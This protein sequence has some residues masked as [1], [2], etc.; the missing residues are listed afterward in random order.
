[1]SPASPTQFSMAAALSI[2]RPD[3]PGGAGQS[4]KK[5]LLIVTAIPWLSRATFWPWKFLLVTRTKNESFAAESHHWLNSELKKAKSK[6]AVCTLLGIFTV[7]VSSAQS[8]TFTPLD[9]VPAVS[10][11]QSVPSRG[12]S[13]HASFSWKP[14]GSS[15]A[16]SRG[17]AAP[18]GPL[19]RPAIVLPCRATFDPRLD[20]MATCTGL[21]FGVQS[22]S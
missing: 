17:S 16:E 20:A 6:T 19:A 22:V 9:W 13:L 18:Q 10:E 12:M 14:A 8:C 11:V 5:P 15:A 2:D 1:M 7:R 4:W 3:G 21:V